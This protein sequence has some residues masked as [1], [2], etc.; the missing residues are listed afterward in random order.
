LREIETAD[1]GLSP[2]EL[3]CNEAQERYC[4]AVAQSGL[5]RFKAIAKRERCGYSIVGKTQGGDHEEKRLVL[6]DRESQEHPEPVNLSMP[7]LFGKV[8][9]LHRKVESRK[10]ELPPF[11]NSLV[12][13]RSNLED[14]IQRVLNL[15]AVASKSYLIT[16]SDRSVK[17]LPISLKKLLIRGQV[18]GLC[19]RDPMVGKYQAPVADCG[20]TATS[21]TSGI[22][23]GEA[24]AIGEKPTLALIDAAASARMAVAEAL[25]N[26]A[27]SHIE[28]RQERIKL[29][30]NWM[31]AINH[32]GEGAAIYE[33]VE[34]VTKFCI[35][36]GI[37]IPVGKDSTSMQ[38]KWT[39]PETKKAIEVTAPLSLV[40]TAVAPVANIRNTWTPALRRDEEEGVGE[41]VLLMVDLAMG[42]K[43][44]GGSAVAQVFGQ[45]GDEAPD[46]R[47]KDLIKD[48]FDA[49]EQLHE[50]GIVLA[51][52]DISDGGLFTCLVEMCIAGRYGMN[53][54]LDTIC[55]ST[56]TADVI[57]TLF[58]EELGA[59]FQ[60]RKKD[61]INFHRCLATCGPPDG[62]I[63]KIGKP[64]SLR[65][66]SSEQ[67]AINI[68]YRMDLLYHSAI[69]KLHQA[70]ASTSYQMAKLRDNPAC[71]DSEYDSLLDAQDPGLSYNLTF[72]PADDI[73]LFTTK[74][75]NRLLLTNRPRVAI[76]REQGSNGQSEMAFAF[77][78]AGFTAVDV[79]MSD[80]LSG[81]ESCQ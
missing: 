9:K 38:A 43:A 39:D 56:G 20:V 59:V 48:Y 72:K 65:S 66:F 41:T 23:T 15:P 27:A 75:S 73:L 69:S 78:S 49:I 47:N 50:A 7:V 80:L 53:V 29:S 35:E 44:M 6:M 8:P 17:S 51:Y 33:A 19:V 45:L 76:L 46:V 57:S 11:D 12:S 13:Y 62:L 2:L 24:M 30:A 79:H 40:V 25:L 10:L 14:T 77:M 52:H 71:A 68:Y 28:G 64:S 26:I 55:K 21:L 34:Q 60:L 1:R 61:E 70:W 81:R 74:L 54:T 63:K 42:H 32:P 5:N 37:S 4:I 58:N 67:L 22:K 3:W 36:L 31:S 18:G 16:I